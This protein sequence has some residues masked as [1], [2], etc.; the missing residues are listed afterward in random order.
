MVLVKTSLE[1]GDDW[2]NFD[3]SE[4]NSLLSLEG[5]ILRPSNKSGEISFGLNAIA[6]S[7]IAGFALEERVSFLVSLFHISSLFASFS[8]SK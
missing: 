6:N 5:N 8:L 1:L 2:G 7:E 3:S 4:K